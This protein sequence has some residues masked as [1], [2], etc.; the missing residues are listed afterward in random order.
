M[1]LTLYLW[2][3]A[4]CACAILGI[5]VFFI[6][7]EISQFQMILWGI[8][9]PVILFALDA[10]FAIIMHSLPRKWMNPYRKCFTVS[11]K[12][13]SLYRKTKI[14]VWKDYIP[15]T[16]KLTT[17]LSKSKIEGTQSD[18]LYAFLEETCYAEW[19]HYGMALCSFILPFISPRTLIPVMIMP[20][21]IVNFLLNIPPI[22]IQRNNRPKLLAMYEHSKK[23]EEKQQD[24]AKQ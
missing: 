17:G 13:V 10:L 24:K 6:H 11:R 20:Q 9:G 23:T 22:L 16:G 18:Y 4:V 2:T 14:V 1:H 5:N 15:D 21:V 12:E 7:P 19:V 3:I 8:L